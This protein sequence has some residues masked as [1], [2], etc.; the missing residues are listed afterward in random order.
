MKLAEVFNLRT[1]SVRIISTAPSGKTDSDGKPYYL[2]ILK[3]PI[4]V[5]CSYNKEIEPFLTNEVLV[6]EA[7]A[8]EDGWMGNAEEG[9]FRINEETKTEWVADYSTSQDAVLYQPETIA[10]WKKN[11]RMEEGKNR[12]K[13]L[14]QRIKDKSAALIAKK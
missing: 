6:R 11:S 9:Y 3:N 12:I 10:A 13:S 14:N 4:T 1:E 5:A 2:A 8:Q 7:A